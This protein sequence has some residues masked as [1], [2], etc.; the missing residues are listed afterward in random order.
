MHVGRDF[1]LV[2]AL[3]KKASGISLVLLFWEVPS[4]IAAKLPHPYQNFHF[5]NPFDISDIMTTIFLY[6]SLIVRLQVLQR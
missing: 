3:H 2:V 1:L 4:I 5:I 6:F